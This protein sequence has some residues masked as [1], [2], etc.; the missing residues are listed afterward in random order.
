MQTLQLSTIERFWKKVIPQDCGYH[1]S[2]WRWT[3]QISAAGYGRF[4]QDSIDGGKS[5]FAHRFAY[6]YFIGRVPQNLVLDHM[7]KNK[8]CVNPSHLRCVSVK[9]N[10]LCG[11]APT[12]INARK[13]HCK[14]GHELSGNNLALPKD[15]SRQCKICLKNRSIKHSKNRRR[16]NSNVSSY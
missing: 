13:T 9:E 7:C 10:V 2:C 12:A 4:R 8:F 1:T 3:A 11:I 15:G 16:D 6:E 5:R 14:Y